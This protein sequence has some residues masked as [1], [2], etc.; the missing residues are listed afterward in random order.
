[1]RCTAV[2]RR[3]SI[4]NAGYLGQRGES[5]A[6]LDDFVQLIAEFFDSRY[7]DNN[8]VT[9]TINFLDDSQETASRVL[10]QVKREMFPFD[11]DIIIQ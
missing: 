4:A 8:G 11:S 10:P 5:L 1:M 6:E 7:G 9:A 2:A 3:P